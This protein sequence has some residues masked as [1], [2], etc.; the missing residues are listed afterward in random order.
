MAEIL[1]LLGIVQAAG[2]ADEEVQEKGSFRC[3]FLKK[4]TKKLLSV[5]RPA[6][7]GDGGSLTKVFLLLFLQKKKILIRESPLRSLP[8]PSPSAR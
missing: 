2:F 4:R 1:G 8:R 6:F 3:S 5:W 7:T